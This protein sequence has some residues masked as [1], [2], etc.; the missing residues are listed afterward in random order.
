LAR[1]FEDGK[2]IVMYRSLEEM[3]EKVQYYLEHEEE[4][5]QI[6]HAGYEKVLREY[7]YAEKLRRIF[8]Q[9]PSGIIQNMRE[10]F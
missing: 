1:E 4:R 3:V 2:E 9:K 6:A 5:R 7:N 8:E 10:N